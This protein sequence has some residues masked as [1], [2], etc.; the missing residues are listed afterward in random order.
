M[1]IE[2][3]FRVDLYYEDGDFDIMG[4]FDSYGEAEEYINQK[5]YKGI[6]YCINKIFASEEYIESI[7]KI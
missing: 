7:I 6:Y 1:K 3:K 5:S 2:V 4:L